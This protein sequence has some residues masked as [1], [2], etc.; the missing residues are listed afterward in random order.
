MDIEGGGVGTCVIVST[1]KIKLKRD[2]CTHYNKRTCAEK[3]VNTEHIAALRACS[4]PTVSGRKEGEGF[5]EEAPSSQCSPC[6]GAGSRT[7]GSG[8]SG[9]RS[10]MCLCS[11]A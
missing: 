9:Q 8:C 1:I 6:R 4:W 11:E 3:A 5:L 7:G 2:C 10:H